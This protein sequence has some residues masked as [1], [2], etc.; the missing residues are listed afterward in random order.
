MGIYDRHYIREQQSGGRM[1]G[2]RSI[3]GGMSAWSVTTWLIIICIAIHVI[4]GFL[5]VHFPQFEKTERYLVPSGISIDDIDPAHV[6]YEYRFATTRP[7]VTGVRPGLAYVPMVDAQRPRLANVPRDQLS[8]VRDIPV[9]DRPPD[10]QA[11]R[12]D[13]ERGTPQPQIQDVRPG[14]FYV[15]LLDAMSGELVGWREFAVTLA[16]AECYVMPPLQKLLFFS[17]WRGFLGIEFWRLIGFQ[18]LHGDMWHLAFNMIALFFFGPM[19][20]QYLGS[21]RYLA[22]YLLCGI[23]GAL[24]YALLNLLGYTAQMMGID[25]NIPGLLFNNP[26][27]PLVGASAGVFGVLMAGAYIAPRTTVLLFFILPMQLRTLA[28]ALVVLAV[29]ILLTGGRNAGGEAGHLGGAMAGWY[30]IRNPR[31]LHGFFDFLGRFDPTSKHYRGPRPS[32][33]GQ[34]S[35]SASDRREV[36]RILDKI[37]REGLASLTDEEKRI[38]REAS[39]GE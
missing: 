38:L 28:Y 36:D 22:F 23:F 11:I 5:G 9:R 16:W 20:E 17:T 10:T 14:M 25:A 6:E 26:T 1:G 13:F 34:S 35:G 12:L 33:V 31:H 32:R 3:I 30:F 15:P 24:F 27:V 21:K 8:P 37:S 2:G 4:D 29:F 19:I 18:F 7:P 39:R